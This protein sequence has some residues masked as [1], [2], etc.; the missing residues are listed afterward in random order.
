MDAVPTLSLD[1]FVTNKEIMMIKLYEY[2][3]CSDYS[4]S[5]TF[6][7]TVVS[8]KYILS[9]AKDGVELKGMVD[10]A[11]S[12]MYE[13]YF[14]AVTVDSVVSETDNKIKLDV[15]IRCLDDNDITHNLSKSL[16]VVDNNIVGFDAI[17]ESYRL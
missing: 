4:Q 12:L 6:Y 1:G 17:Q 11:L 13:S 9:E 7:G 2:F 15:N 3:L 14:R 10:E 16:D 5:N 8:L